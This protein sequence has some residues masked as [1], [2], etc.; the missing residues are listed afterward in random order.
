MA[1]RIGKHR[2]GPVPFQILQARSQLMV[3]SDGIFPSYQLAGFARHP[4]ENGSETGFGT[5]LGLIVRLVVSNRV[6]KAIVLDLVGVAGWAFIFP[7]ELF[8]AQPVAAKE[9]RLWLAFPNNS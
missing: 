6:E 4:A 9:P 8:R 5:A 3:G 2:R 7:Q 1:V